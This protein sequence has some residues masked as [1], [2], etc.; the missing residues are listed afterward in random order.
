MDLTA[1]ADLIARQGERIAGIPASPR[2][3]RCHFAYPGSTHGFATGGDGAKTVGLG[4][5]SG[6]DPRG[7]RVAVKKFG[8][9]SMVSW[10]VDTSLSDRDL[11]ANYYGASFSPRLYPGQTL[12]SSLWIPADAPRGLVA[13]IYCTDRNRGAPGAD[14]GVEPRESAR[15]SIL[16]APGV[17]L[18]PGTSTPLEF[19]LPRIENG[20]IVE[21]GVELR[22]TGQELWNGRVVMEWFDWDGPADYSCDFSRERP[23]S[24]AVSQ[25]TF[26]S[27]F[28]R[29]EGKILAGSGAEGAEA[30]TGDIDWEDYEVA[31]RIRPL[32]GT[33]HLLLARVRSARRS[34]GFGFDGPG[35]LRLVAKDRGETRILAGADYPWEPGREYELALRVSGTQLS[36]LVDGIPLLGH[37]LGE[38]T[39]PGGQIGLATGAGGSLR[40]SR[41]DVRP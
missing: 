9:K 40:C 18:R 17:A 34:C 23:D 14:P 21:A 41:M 13:G 30:Y 39:L 8:K 1:C 36:A 29:L 3:P 38:G 11:S 10:H 32:L 26:H 33:R 31:A 25:W 19:R 5:S 12:R 22:T 2:A 28:W 7:L 6:D 27:G 37:R 15:G 20:H 35:R 24:G 4:H 16:R